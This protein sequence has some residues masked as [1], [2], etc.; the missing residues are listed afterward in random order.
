MYFCVTAIDLCPAR[1]ANTRTLM[2]LLAR[3]VM[4]VLRPEWLLAP[5]MPAAR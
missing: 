5:E 1:L 2:P 3:L 4:N